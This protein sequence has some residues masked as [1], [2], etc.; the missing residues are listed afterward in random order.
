M[1]V[2]VIRV[3]ALPEVRHALIRVVAE[4]CPHVVGVRTSEEHLLGVL[5]RQD[6]IVLEQHHRLCGQLIGRLS[7]LWAIQFDMSF[8][9]Q[10]CALVEHSQCSL[11]S[12]HSLHRFLESLLRHES[13]LDCLI[14]MLVGVVARELHIVARIH[15]RCSLLGESLHVGLLRD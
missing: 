5:E 10:L 13:L 1:W 6:A 15:C 9:I 14:Q 12:E 2:F 11:E 7:F 3:I 4:H 8:L